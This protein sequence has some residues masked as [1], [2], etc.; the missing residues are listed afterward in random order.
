MRTS[1]SDSC[2][3]S[4]PRARS[5]QAI[6]P[7]APP[8]GPPLA[9]GRGRHR[10]L[11][12]PIHQLAQR[13]GVPQVG[14]IIQLG[15][16]AHPLDV[17]PGAEMPAPAAQYQQPQSVIAVQLLQRLQQLVDHL[18]VEGVVAG[19]AVQPQGGMALWVVFELYGVEW[20]LFPRR[21]YILNTPNA[22]SSTSAF[23][24]AEIAS[25]STSRV[26]AGSI[27]PSSHS[28]ALE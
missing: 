19:R 5:Q 12:Q 4:A 10:Q 25:P 3:S 21:P 14:G 18:R 8:K 17:R 11:V 15:G 24:L 22:V 26:W 28:R 2:A 13:L 7:Q 23:R 27:T 6:S 9:H 20:H 1:D 16:L